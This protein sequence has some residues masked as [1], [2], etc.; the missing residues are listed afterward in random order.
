VLAP[1]TGNQIGAGFFKGFFR[2]LLKARDPDVEYRQLLT[3]P[4]HGDPVTFT[5]KNAVLER[6]I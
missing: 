2:S 3:V 6:D 4:R 1:V 5:G